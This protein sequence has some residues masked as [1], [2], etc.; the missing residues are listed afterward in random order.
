MWTVYKHTAPNGKVY[1]GITGQ[2]PKKRWQNG[3]GYKNNKHFYSAIKSYCWEN[4]KHEI[5][6]TGLTK[7]QACAKEFELI[8]YYDS[9]N[10]EKGYNHSTGGE[11]GALGVHFSAERRRKLSESHKGVHLSAETRQKISEANKGKYISSETRKKLS[12]ANKGQIPWVKG[13]HL[14]TETRQKISEANKGKTPWDKGKHRSA[15]TRRKISE[16]N[17]GK[18]HKSFHL[19]P[20]ARWKISESK[21]GVNNPN[22]GKH[23]SDETRKKLSESH[24]RV[25]LDN[26]ELRRRLSESHKGKT[27]KAVICI[28]T[29]TLYSSITEAA[30]SIGVTSKAIS[31][32][33]RGK[34]KTSGGY[35]WKYAEGNN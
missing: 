23:P 20:E 22:Y 33:L 14:S 11:C 32:V 21:K 26:P 29:G 1:I 4:I 34:S 16:S 7:E 18:P 9:N 6:E 35:H 28:E 30:E 25:Y 13:K 8:A 5:L 31:K 10:R 12:E 27:V 2:K 15:E 17:K 3:Y 24:K 19:S